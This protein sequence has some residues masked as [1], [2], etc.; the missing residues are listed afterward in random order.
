MKGKHLGRQIYGEVPAH[1]LGYNILY[2]I[3]LSLLTINQWKMKF[4]KDPA[5]LNRKLPLPSQG[6]K[7]SP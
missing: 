5:K 6:Y 1:N 4:M 7:A 2:P 3:E